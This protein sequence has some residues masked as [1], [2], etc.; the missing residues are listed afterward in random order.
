MARVKELREKVRQA[1]E[2]RTQIAKDIAAISETADK[3]DRGF[4]PEDDTKRDELMQKHD[5]ADREVRNLGDQLRVAESQETGEN[6][7]DANREEHERRENERKSSEFRRKGDDKNLPPTQIERDLGMRGW[8]LGDKLENV[9]G[10]R[11]NDM[12]AAVKKCQLRGK[13]VEFGFSYGTAVTGQR[14]QR[15]RTI[16]EANEQAR[17]RLEVRTLMAKGELSAAESRALSGQQTVTPTAGGHTVPDEMMHSIILA[18]L[19]WG[20]MQPVSTT[21]TT[22]GGNPWPWPMNDDTSHVAVPIAENTA[23][24][25]DDP[26]F[27]QNTLGAHKYT[28]QLVKVPQEMLEDSILDVGSFIANIFGQRFGRGLNIDFTTGNAAT[29]ARGCLI[30]ATDSTIT[31]GSNTSLDWADELLELK[32][33]VDP[34]YRARGAHW[35][36]HDQTLLMMKKIK[37]SQQ[38]PLWLPSLTSGEAPTFD[39]DPVQVN[40][41]MATGATAKAIMY[42]DFKNFVIREV[43]A[44]RFRRFEELFGTSD[45]VGFAAFKRVDSLLMDAGTHPVSFLTLAS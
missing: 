42:G 20:G 14:F 19:A 16:E 30:D 43:A 5:R 17:A 10:D 38:R 34:A 1:E 11:G 25:E 4:T 13:E 26:D 24:G 31:T 41:A 32:H 22:A 15:P 6:I 21:L 44:Y 33:K 12:R 27:T 28:S 36:C 45:Q 23:I 29:R 8:M 3:E 39:G 40:Q 7:R 37:D 35:M 9:E 2:A 18:E